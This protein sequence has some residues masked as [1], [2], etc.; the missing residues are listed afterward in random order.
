MSKILFEEVQ[1]FRQKTWLLVLIAATSLGVVL[2]FFYGM[3]WQIIKGEP[4]GNR[5]MTNDGLVATSIAV[6]VLMGLIL[7]LIFNIRLETRVDEEAIYFR[8]FPNQWKWSAAYRHEIASY[9]IRKIGFWGSSSW[10]FNNYVF[11]KMKA[12]TISGNQVLEIKLKNDHRLRIGTQDSVALE[13]AMNKMMNP[14]Y[15]N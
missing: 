10:G 9:E 2:P 5:P 15:L 12:M 7:W 4:W 1:S 11:K 8:F 3:Y 6:F 14:K 13:R